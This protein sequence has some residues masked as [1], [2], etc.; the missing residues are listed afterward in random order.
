MNK[1]ELAV[2]TD[3]AWNLQVIGLFAIEPSQLVAGS[4]VE[5]GGGG[6]TEEKKNFCGHTLWH[7]TAHK[8]TPLPPPP[9]PPPHLPMHHVLTLAYKVLYWMNFDTPGVDLY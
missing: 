5:W 4:E 2:I 1:R 9:P 8:I 7:I 6:G 3:C